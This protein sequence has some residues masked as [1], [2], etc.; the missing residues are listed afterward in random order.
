[1]DEA[2]EVRKIEARISE[3]HQASMPGN[4]ST[5]RVLPRELLKEM[6]RLLKRLGEL[7]P[8]LNMKRM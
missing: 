4:N 2:E 3:I 7:K 6:N 5:H 8:E 1:M